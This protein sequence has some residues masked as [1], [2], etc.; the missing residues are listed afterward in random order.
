MSGQIYPKIPTDRRR[1]RSDDA[2]GRNEQIFC[3][4]PSPAFYWSH[5]R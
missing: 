1:V 5:E 4:P 3:A 2:R